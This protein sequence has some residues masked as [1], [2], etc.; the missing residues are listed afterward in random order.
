MCPARPAASAIFLTAIGFLICTPAAALDTP[1]KPPEPVEVR[2]LDRAGRVLLSQGGNA[3]AVLQVRAITTTTT[4]TTPILSPDTAKKTLAD[5]ALAPITSG[6]EQLR[7]LS[8]GIDGKNPQNNVSV[9]L[10]ARRFAAGVRVLATSVIQGPAYEDLAPGESLGTPQP[11]ELALQ[12]FPDGDNATLELSHLDGRRDPL[13]LEQPVL[14]A[15]RSFVF[16]NKKQTRVYVARSGGADWKIERLEKSILLTT[17]LQ[18]DPRER[19]KFGSFVIYLGAGADS[20][21]PEMSP[22]TLSK[23]VTPARELIEGA[24]RVYASGTDPFTLA[25]L[26]VI[27]EV[28]CPPR[29]DGEVPIKRLPCFFWQAPSAAPAEGEFRF[30]FA[31]PT[32]GIYGIRVTVVTP[33]GQVKGEA[34]SFSAGPPVSPGFIRA[35]KGERTFR[36]DDGAGFV[37]YGVDLYG[38]SLSGVDTCRKAFVELARND[39][40]TVRVSLEEVGRPFEP[41]GGVFDPDA[42]AVL[43][44]IFF[45]AQ[46]RDIHLLFSIETAAGITTRSAE[47]PYFNELGGPLAATPEFFRNLAAKKFY[48]GRLTYLA[49][50]YSAFRSL[51]AWELLRDVDDAWPI[52]KNNPEDRKLSVRESDLCR[53]ARRDVQEWAAEMALHLDGVDQHDH[54]VAL[55]TAVSAETPWV[56]LENL[57]NVDFVLHSGIPAKPEDSKTGVVERMQAWSDAARQPGRP[58]RPFWLSRIGADE[59]G[60]L[61]SIVCGMAGAPFIAWPEF[62]KAKPTGAGALLQYSRV[63]E[64][65]VYRDTRNEMRVLSEKIALN[66]GALRA[67]GRTARRGMAFW[68]TPEPGANGEVAGTLRLPALTEGAY[69]VFWLNA[70]SGVVVKKEAYSAASRKVDQP[71]APV[72][73]AWPSGKDALLLLVIR[74]D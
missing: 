34:T 57:E 6:N 69:D 32:E 5:A 43:D 73:L 12:I 67:R 53:R 28:A 36:R 72:E 48:E 29:A 2:M 20:A 10:R 60:S 55:S 3:L 51:L 46:A 25:S 30:R 64:E 21:P 1:A 68:L 66:S 23:P 14:R 47:H 42:A 45:A 11:H 8:A 44:E 52:L 24:L 58:H 62:Q 18:P 27:A 4:T 16:E 22:I 63:V 65:L 40:N 50:R 49:A 26:A 70:T 13:P 61:A 15:A 41:R 37:P 33:A 74:A 71:Q 19:G 39:V 17:R 59:N 56:D 38:S 9:L 35:K 7:E 54:P 31:P